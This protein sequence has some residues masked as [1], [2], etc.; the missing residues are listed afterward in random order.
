MPPPGHLF[1]AE[2]RSGAKPG[3]SHVR[4]RFDTRGL[5]IEHEGAP[6]T[7]W[8]YAGIAAASGMPTK[9]TP[10]VILNSSSEPGATLTVESQPFVAS[11]RQAAPQ[12]G[13]RPRGP[14]WMPMVVAS[15][16]MIAIF[17]ALIL[18]VFALFPFKSVARRIP[19]DTRARIGELA[20]TE[21]T[22]GHRRCESSAG[23][24]ALNKLVDRLSKASGTDIKFKVRVVDW[25]LVNAFAVMG[26]QIVLTK[27]LLRSASSPDEVAGVLGHEMGHVIEVH[28]E[29]AVLQALGTVIGVQIL[30]GGWTPDLVTEAA[31]K[32]LVLRHS[33][34]NETEADAVA[35]RLLAQARIA[36]GP[37]AGFF[38]KISKE[39]ETDKAKGLSLPDVFSTHPPP[40]ERAKRAKAQPAYPSTPALSPA[41]WEALRSIC[42]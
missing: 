35:L 19:E 36:A 11:I 40:P 31:S 7:V 16:A 32:L 6:A 38:E 41:E 13:Q 28:P 20:M 4:V 26:N 10:R 8:P 25:S 24:T 3:W 18:V 23:N 39:G 33:R 21:M 22:K 30:L 29:A 34:D 14:S 27:G 37:F 15:L 17:G 5:I 1:D 12:L 2:H 9:D 42:G